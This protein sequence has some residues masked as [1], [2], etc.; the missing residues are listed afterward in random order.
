MVDQKFKNETREL[1]EYQDV[2]VGQTIPLNGEIVRHHLIVCVLMGQALLKLVDEW[3]AAAPTKW[4]R[5]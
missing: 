1:P 4:E 5:A 3:S 2:K